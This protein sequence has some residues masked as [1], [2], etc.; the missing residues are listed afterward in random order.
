MP[1]KGSKEALQLEVEKLRAELAEARNESRAAP[2]DLIALGHP[3]DDTLEAQKY[4][5]RAN[6]INAHEV[7]NDETLKPKE[8]WRWIQTISETVHKLVPKSRIFEAENL[9][10]GDRAALERKKPRGAKL[11]PAP[12]SPG[13]VTKAEAKKKVA[14]AR[15]TRKEKKAAAGRRDAGPKLEPAPTP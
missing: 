5:L 8:R 3:P 11:E 12:E 10:K 7:I 4:L 2:R 6:M 1:R 15:R 13:P 14:V 9:I